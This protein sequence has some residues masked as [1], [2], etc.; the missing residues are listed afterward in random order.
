MSDRNQITSLSLIALLVAALL[1][2]SGSVSAAVGEGSGSTPPNVVIIMA[3]DLGYGDVGAFGGQVIATPRIDDL[4][5]SGMRLDSFYAHPT[6]TPS[7]AA[8][9]TGRYSQRIGVPGAIGAW[10]PK[11][12]STEEVTLAEVLKTVGY[13]TATYGKWHVGDAPEQL[14]TAQGFDD[15][16]GILWGP[17]GIPLVL[18]DSSRGVLEYEPDLTINAIDVTERSIAFIDQSVAAM[19]PFLC[20]VSF[21]APHEPATA[22]PGFQGISADGRDYGDSVEELDA[23][24]GTIIDH[25]TALDLLDDT[26]IVFLSD[27]GATHDRIPYQDG[28]N[29]PFSFGKGSTWEGGVRVPACVSWPGRVPVG[30]VQSAPL[31]IADL[32]PTLAGWAGATLDPKITL[33][34]V[35]VRSVFEGGAPDPSRVVHLSDKSDFNAV[36]RG[37]YK[38]RLGELYDLE[39]DPG[40]LVDLSNI[41]PA[42][43]A[44]LAQELDAIKAS[45]LADSRPG[46]NSSRLS[47]RFR[48]EF[49][50]PDPPVHG[51][52][53]GSKTFDSLVLAFVDS[54][55]DLDAEIIDSSGQGTPSTPHRAISL[56]DYTDGIRLEGFVPNIAPGAPFTVALWYRLPDEGLT[57]EIVVMDIG[58]DEAG[59]SFTIGDAGIVGDDLAPGR[60]DD[61]LVRVGGSFSSESS[62]LAVDLPDVTTVPYLNLAAVLAEDGNLIVYINGLEAGRVLA[63]GV[64][65]GTDRTWAFLSAHGTVGGSA[66]PGVLPFATSRCI[67]ELAAVSIIERELR[68]NEMSSE[69]ARAALM[70]YCQGRPNSTGNPATFRLNGIIRRADNRMSIA[71]DSLPP[72]TVGFM[73]ASEVQLRTDVAQGTLCIAGPIRRFSNQVFMADATGRIEN[74]IDFTIAPIQVLDPLTSTWNFQFWY[75]DGID[76]NFSNAIHLTFSN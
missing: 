72:S 1:G 11:G 48:A 22:S 43:A 40:E 29:L 63:T 46:A 8:M 16:R 2:L 18:G 51:V 70:M 67:G 59:L 41:L 49:A 73:L 44:Q 74:P 14:P 60:L 56:S 24:V 20:F 28:S 9:L 26:I 32:M 76:S 23:S 71:V 19:E 34:G 53:W 50:L 15:F 10:A 66:G 58:D 5:A 55:P 12:L 47:A 3:D 68:P 36:R 75:R 4:C 42:E 7:R 13:R 30:A 45:V 33:D 38:Y 27:N 57:E 69:Y 6:C 39:V 21:V 65:S 54:D 61:L 25:L 31:F 37:R 35:D 64:D 17:T 52:A 62:S